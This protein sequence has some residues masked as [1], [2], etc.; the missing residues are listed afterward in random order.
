MDSK[1]QQDNSN[2]QI[3]STGTKTGRHKKSELRRISLCVEIGFELLS[4]RGQ[5]RRRFTWKL[6]SNVNTSSDDLDLGD[7]E[8]FC[9]GS[10][11]DLQGAADN[12]F[13]SPH[14]Q[15]LLLKHCHFNLFICPN[16]RYYKIKN[17]I[18]SLGI[19]L[20]SN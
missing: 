19:L 12:L 17:K 5:S 6:K 10:E 20:T 14:P 13:S 9:T 15:P 16:P 2:R 4:K 3:Q 11:A 1:A 8:E 18:K 7:D